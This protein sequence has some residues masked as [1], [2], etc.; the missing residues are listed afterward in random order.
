MD[1]KYE[2]IMDDPEAYSKE[3]ALEVELPFLQS[4]LEGFKL[5][6]MLIGTH[7]PQI[8][9]KIAG[10]LNEEF[11]GKNVLYVISTDLSHYHAYDEAVRMDKE[12]LRIISHGKAD[13]LGAKAMNGTCELCGFAPVIVMMDLYE[14]MGGGEIRLLRYA[15][16]GD[17]TGEK[18]RVVG[19]G[20]LAVMNKFQL[21]DSEKAELLKIARQ[22]I[23]Q[24]VKGAKVEPAKVSDRYLMQPG[25]P[26]VT[27]RKEGEL[28]GCIGHIIAREPLVK[29]VQENAIAAASEDPRFPPVKESELKDIDIEISVLTPPQPV[30]DTGSIV[31]GRDGL[32]IENGY[33]RGV[34][35]PQVPGE[36]GWDLKQFLD[37]ICNKAGL[38]SSA[39][40]D[41]GTK[42][43]R[44][45]ALVFGEKTSD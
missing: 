30:F 4:V 31:L 37:G 7:D 26:F 29:A 27:L 19:Y 1:E 42:L 40:G 33:H 41:P 24:L 44:F 35:L 25:A 9:I 21:A 12:T 16:S 10:S 18:G 20:A 36:I 43:F 11:L 13:E 34:L 5:V 39:I 22:T 38:P 23:G 45:Q 2:W 28:R 14:M 8:L 3:H 15:N 17:V 32:I 6:P